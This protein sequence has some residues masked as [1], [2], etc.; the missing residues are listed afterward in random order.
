M[1]LS[2]LLH[3]CYLL[4]LL[5]DVL[6]LLLLVNGHLLHHH[7]ARVKLLLLQL[8][9]VQLSGVLLLQQLLMLLKRK[10]RG[11]DCTHAVRR[12]RM[13][14][15]GKGGHRQGR[16][17]HDSGEIGLMRMELERRLRRRL[18]LHGRRQ[19]HRARPSSDHASVGSEGGS[20]SSEIWHHHG[21][22]DGGLDDRRLRLHRRRSGRLATGRHGHRGAGQRQRDACVGRTAVHCTYVRVCDRVC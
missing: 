4:L 21:V 9:H 16:R 11:S 12:E 5:E 18:E 19:N 8:G 10:R 22:G 7:A 1:L 3:G 17:A 15:H 6:L 20:C 14:R 13:H 2:V